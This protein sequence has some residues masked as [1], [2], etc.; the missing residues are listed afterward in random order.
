MVYI[1][2]HHYT[3]KLQITVLH[4]ID[5]LWPAF[6]IFGVL[7]YLR[8]VLFNPQPTILAIIDSKLMHNLKRSSPLWKE[9]K[10]QALP[11]SGYKAQVKKHWNFH[12]KISILLSTLL[13]VGK[14][15]RKRWMDR[16]FKIFFCFCDERVINLRFC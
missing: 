6:N 2:S 12:T 15:E 10:G 13:L 3:Y 1:F 9:G 4:D 8:C 14:K 7:N 5:L 11:L 16:L